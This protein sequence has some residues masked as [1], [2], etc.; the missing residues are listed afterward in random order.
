MKSKRRE[1]RE[2]GA[3]FFDE[4]ERLKKKMRE[5]EEEM[6]AVHISPLFVK[7][8]VYQFLVRSAAPSKCCKRFNSISCWGLLVLGA[9]LRQRGRLPSNFPHFHLFQSKKKNKIPFF[10]S[11]FPIYICFSSSFDIVFP[12]P[13]PP[14]WWNK[15]KA[16]K[17]KAT[18]KKQQSK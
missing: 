10:S 9:F 7:R 11:P 3:I 5:K 13:P 6:K 15:A 2:I 14:Y 17:K 4:G 16:K 1:N 18:K 12:P 8:R